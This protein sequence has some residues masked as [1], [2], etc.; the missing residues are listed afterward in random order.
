MSISLYLLYD[1]S[2]LPFNYEFVI[3]ILE[4]VF[5]LRVYDMLQVYRGCTLDGFNVA[6]KVQ[7]PN[8]RETVIRD[9]YLLRRGV[10]VLIEYVTAIE[11]E[12]IISKRIK[13]I[14]H[15][16]PHERSMSHS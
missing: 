11:F 4:D 2:S 12:L 8:V 13:H 5:Q 16:L 15:Y 9:I 6:V 10:S 3:I 14:A 1:R 7:R